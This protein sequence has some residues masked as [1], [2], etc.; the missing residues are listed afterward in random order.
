MNF[1]LHWIVEVLYFCCLTSC[2]ILLLLDRPVASFIAVA[3]A[4][5]H[6]IPC[7]HMYSALCDVFSGGKGIH[8]PIPLYKNASSALRIMLEGPENIFLQ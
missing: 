4:S 2:P 1:I 3:A 5:K 6:C 7:F 8:I